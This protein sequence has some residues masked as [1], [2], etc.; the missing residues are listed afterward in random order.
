MCEG[1]LGE[2]LLWKGLL[3][4]GAFLWGKAR[5]TSHAC[6]VGFAQAL[7]LFLFSKRAA[8]GLASAAVVL[9]R[10]VQRLVFM[11]VDSVLW[12]RHFFRR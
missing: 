12:V 3:F 10:M 1:H 4:L 8:C 11:G 9:L 5:G 6:F 7:A 2:M